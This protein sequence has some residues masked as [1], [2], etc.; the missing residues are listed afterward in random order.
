MTRAK[1]S[2]VVSSC[3]AVS[4][5]G[6]V[7]CSGSDDERAGSA[8]ASGSG[9]GGEG[10]G[11]A[12]SV[13]SGG[14]G[15]AGSAG[16]GAGGGASSGDIAACR[17][18]VAPFAEP[19]VAEYVQWSVNGQAMTATPPAGGA[20]FFNGF[21]N[22]T[23]YTASFSGSVSVGVAVQQESFAAGTYRCREG[24]A[25]GMVSVNALGVA[26]QSTPGTDCA[27][28][29]EQDVEDGG[30]LKGTFWAYY[31]A[32]EWPLKSAGGCV[33]GRFDVTDAAD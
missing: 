21:L 10:N 26:N 30:R 29:Y 19:G 22:L 31:P 11:A 6:L 7:G 23:T 27:V 9:R 15:A 25:T 14:A 1:W 17:D 5:L 2:L 13:T 12:G 24:E 8:G 16:N 28:T 18:D 33:H 4:A 3:V 20:Y 32:V